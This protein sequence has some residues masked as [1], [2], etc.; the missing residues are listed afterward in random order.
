[1]VQC[2]CFILFRFAF[3]IEDSDHDNKLG[4]RLLSSDSFVHW[5]LLEQTAEYSIYSMATRHQFSF[6]SN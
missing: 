5:N 3:F 1:M 2:D 6:L 4:D